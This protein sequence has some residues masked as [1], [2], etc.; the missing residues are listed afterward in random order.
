M[1]HCTSFFSEKNLKQQRAGITLLAFFLMSVF[2]TVP[3]SGQGDSAEADTS[4][5]VSQEDYYQIATLHAPED[6]VPEVGGLAMLPNGKLAIATRRGEV[7]TV[8]NPEMAGGSLP[9][10]EKFAQGLYEPLGLVYRDGSLYTAQRGELTKLTD[11]S[12]DGRADIYERVA[13]WP[14]SGHYHEYSFGP[15]FLPDGNMVVTGNVA[16]G[17]EKWWEAESRVP[18]RGWTMIVS[19][20]GEVTPFA[21]GMR[22]PSGIMVNDEGDI[23]Y[24]ENQGD[25]IGSGFITHVEE[26]DF[27]GNPA[28][29]R[30]AGHSDSPVDV[31]RDQIIDSEEPMYKTAERVPGMKLPAVWVPHT[32][33]GISTSGMIQDTEG[34]FGPFKGH[35][36]V[37][38]Q[39][40]AMINRVF[41]EKVN[42]VYQGAVFPFLRDFE[43]GVLRMAWGG[44]RSMYVGMTDRGWRSTGRATHGLQRVDWNGEVPFEMKTIKAE[45]DGFLIEFTRPV[46]QKLVSDPDLYNVTSF[47]YM[48]RYDYGSPIINQ[49]A[50]PVRGIQVA[51]DG[52]SVRLVVDNMRRYHVHEVRLGDLEDESGTPLLHKVGYYTLN[53]FPEGESLDP[54]EWTAA[55]ETEPAG[56][57]SETVPEQ[58]ESESGGSLPKRMTELPESWGNGPDQTIE[59]GTQ[60]G[61]EYDLDEIEVV[62]GSRVALIFNNNDTMQHNVVIVEEGTADDVGNAAMNLGLSGEEMD[63][64][65][66]MDEVLFYTSLLQPGSAETIYF[67]APDTPGTYTYVC[68]FP[69]HHFVM[70]GTLV[71]N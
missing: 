48:Y 64:V 51:E 29:L 36:F 23:F 54:D 41:M 21:T 46:D 31:Q 60:P 45:P 62:A 5:G 27:T 47:T 50:S 28:G 10:F 3:V 53:E 22:S 67:T 68:T 1:K 65:P 18:W 11:T 6:V 58:P 16:F 4:S 15:A 32:L 8:G 39:G 59:L 56:Q 19:P 69:G 20:E 25:W 37:G 7:W 44:E 40:H 38:D 55:K 71:V 26:G 63:Y 52:M 61:L 2:F 66:D 57:V 24:T 35:Y 42:G 14:I 70:R 49:E 30:W 34:V 17:D 43:S 13:V 9:Y 12:G 33:L